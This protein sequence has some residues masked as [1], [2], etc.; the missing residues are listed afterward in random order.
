MKAVLYARVSSEIQERRDTISLQGDAARRWCE[1]HGVELVGEYRD[2]DVSGTVM[3]PERPGGARLLRDA[4]HLREAGVSLV[5]LYEWSRIGR[6]PWVVFGAI[7][8]LEQVAGLR[9]K[10][11]TQEADTSSPERLLLLCIGAGV[12]SLERRRI[13]QRSQDACNMLARAGT[14][15]GG[16]PPLGYRVVGQRREA[17]LAVDD[18]PAPGVDPA[19]G[20]SAADLIRQI[21]AWSAAGDALLTIA[22]RLTALGVRPSARAD[23]AT[24]WRVDR[25]YQVL[26]NPVY[27]GELRYGAKPKPKSQRPREVIVS[28]VPALVSP[29]EWDAANAA[30]HRRR[31]YS[32]RNAFRSYLLAG[33]LKCG[34]CGRSWHGRTLTRGY[35]YYRCRG[36][37]AA[38]PRAE[39]CPVSRH[40]PAPGADAEIWAYVERLILQPDAVLPEL[41][42]ARQAELGD[43]GEAETRLAA[44]RRAL[45]AREAQRH[46]VIG[47]ARAGVITEAE[48]ARQLG[49]IR[50]EEEPL[51][52]EVAAIQPRA[53]RQAA[54]ERE[55][56]AA[57]AVLESLREEVAAGGLAP[58]RQR[59]IIL[60]LVE[61]VTVR[62]SGADGWEM[63]VRCRFC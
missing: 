3:F 57:P 15:L 43:D 51:A 13:A 54:A 16:L 9:L 34:A 24:T 44:L 1:R 37:E 23:A 38:I 58:T 40:L 27:R 30:M 55:F 22:H 25:V 53:E 19:F 45:A 6:E 18:G 47:W 17:R 26:T 41:L 7:H 52:A 29:A 46:Q 5:L 59:E 50:R 32:S 49:D 14:W 12:D 61:R 4:T 28:D 60:R 21:F 10:S 42:A 39:W 31:S 36:R 2:E 62:W 8:A 11:L 35:A 56:A 33:L 48:L 63:R 20:L